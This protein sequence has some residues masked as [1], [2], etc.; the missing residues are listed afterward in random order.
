MF[1]AEDELVGADGQVASLLTQSVAGDMTGRG[2]GWPTLG[3]NG[4]VARLV[5]CS[6]S[7]E[8]TRRCRLCRLL[9]DW[10][11]RVN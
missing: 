2:V 1:K 3:A 6:G 8:E 9:A 5:Q 11:L 4:Y 7:K 10:T